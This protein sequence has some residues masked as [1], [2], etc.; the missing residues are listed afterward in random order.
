M[1]KIRTLSFFGGSVSRWFSFQDIYTELN[2]STHRSVSIDYKVEI[3]N[4][5]K[6]KFYY[7]RGYEK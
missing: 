2:Q 3:I 7:V 1:I 6:K 5:C 4:T